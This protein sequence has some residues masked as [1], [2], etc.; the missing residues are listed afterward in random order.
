MKKEKG[1]IILPVIL[2]IVAM[3]LLPAEGLAADP[4]QVL[5]EMQSKACAG[6]GPDVHSYF[7]YSSIKNF[8][9]KD[10]SL[11]ANECSDRIR[12]FKNAVDGWARQGPGSPLC[13]FKIQKQSGDSLELR[14]RP[15][16]SYLSGPW[17]LESSNGKLKIVE[18]PR[19]PEPPPYGCGLP[20]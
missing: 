15:M 19:P 12:A 18:L 17:R 8:W 13:T 3:V 10:T 14:F 11:P 7:D 20:D 4:V 2:A 5:K 6:A 1:L 16:Y 9:F